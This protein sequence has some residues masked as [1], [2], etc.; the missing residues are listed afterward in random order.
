[1][2]LIKRFEDILD[3]QE[4]RRLTQQI[5]KLTET[6][7]FSKDF[8]LRDQIRRAVVSSMLILPKGLI[9]TPTRNLPVF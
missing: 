6:G 9:V 8:G 4:V 5:Y 3:W 2:T 7:S 1:M